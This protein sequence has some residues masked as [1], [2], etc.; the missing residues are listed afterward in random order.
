LEYTHAGKNK[1]ILNFRSTGGI[2]DFFTFVGET[3]EEVI[4]L[5]HN[6]I[7]RPYLPPFWALGYH[8]ASMQYDTVKFAADVLVE[9]DLNSIPLES[10]WFD[11]EYMYHFQN[12]IPDPDRFETLA[13]FAESVHKNNQKLIF[14]VDSGF[15]AN[16]SYSIYKEANEQKLLI[17]SNKNPDRFNGNLIGKCWSG[18]AAYVDF[19]NPKSSD[20]WIN[21][22]KGLYNKAKM[23][24]VWLDMNEIESYCDGECP[25]GETS[26]SLEDDN[27]IPYNPLGEERNLETKTL[28][29]NAQYYYDSKDPHDKA[30]KQE[31][32]W[33]S[34]YGTM[35]A[36]AT[37]KFWF[38]ETAVNPKHPFLLSRSTFA[39]AGKYAGHWLGNNISTWLSMKMS[40]AGIMNFNMFGIPLVGADICGFYGKFDQEM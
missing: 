21:S 37:Q 18:L 4:K 16:D 9:Y 20:W 14:I 28:S 12:F 19:T 15:Q 10:I 31:F 35:Q 11:M 7:G 17:K 36:R 26:I 8:Q 40:I 13:I 5:Y 1:S 22:L 29:M 3:P 33:H 23:D 25:N 39:G 2:L 34:L 6:V 30:L 32:N 24:G 38:Y 27:V